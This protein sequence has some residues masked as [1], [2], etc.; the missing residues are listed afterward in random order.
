[1]STNKQTIKRRRFIKASGA[2]AMMI[3]VSQHIFGANGRVVLGQIGTGGRGQTLLR[4]LTNISNVRVASICDLREERLDQAMRYCTGYYPETKKYTDFREMLD[5]ESLDACIVATEVG[6]HAKCVVPVLEAGLHCFSEKPM[7]CTVEKVDQIVK[8]ARKAKG[9]Y[10]V[11]FQRRYAPGFQ[12]SIRQIHEGIAGDITFLQGQW[13]WTWSVGGWVGDVDMSGGELV[14]QACHHMDVM[15]W[16]MKGQHPLKCSA[17]GIITR[18]TSTPPE[19]NSE[20]QSAVAFEFPG[21][22]TFS[23]THLF[24]CCEQFTG[25]KLNVHGQK[26]GVNLVESRFYPRPGMGEPKQLGEKAPN[27][28]YGTPHE[29]QA[30][31]NHVLNNEKPLSNEET[32]RISTLISL[33]GRKAM[34]KRKTKSFEPS[35]VTWDEL[36]STT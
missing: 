32:G 24:Y 31:I 9:I 11:G 28:N 16:V 17:M 29:L 25:E 8:A 4:T 23:Y 27:W 1:M 20:D 18:P 5:K 10:Q 34:Y 2:S 12:D 6:N 7:D 35:L 14:E 19:H 21:G 15:Q 36:G 30:F 33:M 3:G 26:G 22:V 13:Q